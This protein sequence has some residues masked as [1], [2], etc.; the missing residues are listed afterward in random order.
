MVLQWQRNR[1]HHLVS[2]HLGHNARVGDERSERTAECLWYPGGSVW[3]MAGGFLIRWTL[4]M[5]FYISFVWKAPN[6]RTKALLFSIAISFYVFINQNCVPQK[7]V[8]KYHILV[9][10]ALIIWPGN[11]IFFSQSHRIGIG[12]GS[13]S[14]RTSHSS[15]NFHSINAARF[16]QS[17]LGLIL[18][19]EG[20][21][22]R[23]CF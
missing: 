21:P 2:W 17:V 5:G 1:L 9:I 12:W 3:S 18:L 15:A 13:K 23:V 10:L 6:T 7:R 22:T 19:L 11:G 4:F 20:S 14:L 8:V 16:G